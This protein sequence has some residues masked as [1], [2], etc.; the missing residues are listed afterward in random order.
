MYDSYF[1]YIHFHHGPSYI[2]FVAVPYA[3]HFVK[4][5]VQIFLLIT[6]QSIDPFHISPLVFLISQ[7][8]VFHII[9]NET[10]IIILF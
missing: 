9:Q 1:R 7:F 5:Q 3:W 6:V 10:G 8:L 4:I 2:I